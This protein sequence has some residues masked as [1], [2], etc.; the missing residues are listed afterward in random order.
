MD[1]RGKDIFRRHV[2]HGVPFFG[3]LIV[4]NYGQLKS[5]DL[6]YLY[7]RLAL[8]TTHVRHRKTY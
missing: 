4:K 7:P 6:R 3:L 2:T 5:V 1:F 8:G